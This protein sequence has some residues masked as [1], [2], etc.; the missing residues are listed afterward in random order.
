MKLQNILL[1]FIILFVAGGLYYFIDMPAEP[2]KVEIQHFVWMIEMED[3]DHIILELPREGIKESFIKIPEEDKFPWHF[4]DENQSL[5]DSARWGGG[6]P[7]LLSGPGVGRIIAYDASPQKLTEFGLTNP[8][9][10]ITLTLETGKVMHISVGDVTP[11]GA[12]YYVQAPSTN[13]VALVDYTWFDVLAKLIREPPY[14]VV[15]V[16]N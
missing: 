10:L 7:L 6:I 5:V 11:N 4:D 1:L 2:E 8:Q 16:E 9:M 14:A 3:I 15:E 13:D 12:F